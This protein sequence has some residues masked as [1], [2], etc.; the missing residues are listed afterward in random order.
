[1]LGQQA[2]SRHDL[3]GGDAGDGGGHLGRVLRGL[4]GQPLEHRLAVHRL[5]VGEAHRPRAAQ[6][7]PGR[8]AVV[9]A[10]PGIVGDQRAAPRAHGHVARAG[11]PRGT[12][13][14]FGVGHV[15][16]Q[17]QL[18]RIAAHEQR[19]V[20]PLAHERLVVAAF[21][22]QEVDEAERQRA[23]GA[24]PHLQ[25]H[26]GAGGGAD[27]ARIDDHQLGAARL[28]G[29]HVLSETQEVAVRV[30]APEEDAAAVGEIGHGQAV[31]AE[32]VGGGAGVARP[33]AEVRGADHVWR[34][35]QGRQAPQPRLD[36]VEPGAAAGALAERHGARAVGG[37]HG[38]QLRRDEVERL[39]P[40]DALPAGVGVGLG[41]R[42]A[43]GVVHALGLVEE[44]RGGP[45]FGADGAAVRVGRIRVDAED[46]VAGHRR[47]GR[48]VDRAQPA[49]AS[50]RPRRRA[51]VHGH[52]P[53]PI[54]RQ[55]PA[56]STPRPRRSRP[57]RPEHSAG[58]RRRQPGRVQQ[59][60][61]LEAIRKHADGGQAGGTCANSSLIGSAKPGSSGDCRL[62]PSSSVA[63]NWSAASTRRYTSTCRR[64][65]LTIQYSRTPRRE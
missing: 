47:D 54:R 46:A 40:G 57:V 42:A 38:Q 1:M 24:R 29:D 60:A 12:R 4:G 35:E 52:H 20:R 13:R 11:R 50:H 32:R 39:V 49:V 58:R 61:P 9:D 18:A 27:A 31:G 36:L 37:A 59:A 3:C 23:V 65:Q 56:C 48:A 8:A 7:K 6:A 62:S 64:C 53:P 14:E 22:D 44:L 15:G 34:A 51:L 28:R 5:A 45:S 16:G 19:R 17:E 25:E 2:G 30:G 33:L 63:I 21:R 43:H 55:R 41:A 10:A 26:V